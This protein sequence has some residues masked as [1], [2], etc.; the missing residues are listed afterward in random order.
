M[1][2]KTL[3]HLLPLLPLAL[4]A[5]C[6]NDQVLPD[7]Q[8]ADAGIT[9]VIAYAPGAGQP[10]TRTT[11]G[12]QGEDGSYP[13]LWNDGDAIAIQPYGEDKAG[14]HKK[15]TTTI[16]GGTAAFAEFT[17]AAGE[18]DIETSPEGYFAFY[19]CDRLITITTYSFTQIDFKY[20]VPSE[21]T[22]VAGSFQSGINPTIAYAKDLKDGLYFTPLN[23]LVKFSLKG[24][25]VPGLKS[26]KLKSENSPAYLSGEATASMKLNQESGSWVPVG[27]GDNYQ[28]APYVTL[29]AGDEPFQANTDYYM[30]LH[31]SQSN[32]QRDFTLTFTDESDK[33]YVKK[34][35]GISSFY[36]GLIVN[37]GE[38]DLSNAIFN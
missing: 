29:V 17:L 38:I 12:P 11:L 35:Y 26:V 10:A 3:R 28:S 5:A 2:M 20:T 1:R 33:T 30:V 23:V 31:N 19:P 6:S 7:D 32:L 22:A 25:V 4:L 21:Q 34:G 24:D 15:F 14:P 8:P 36:M 16:A 18:G 13:V 9:T 37:L 27:S